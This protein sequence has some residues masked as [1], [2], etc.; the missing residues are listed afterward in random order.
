MIQLAHRQ[1]GKNEGEDMENVLVELA[2]KVDGTGDLLELGEVERLQLVV[3][4]DLE[5]T[6][7]VLEVGHADV[8]E[9]LVA[10]EDQVTGLGQVRG[11]EG[12]ELDTPE[13]ELAG[14]LLERGERSGADVAEGHVLGAGQVG[15]GDLEGLRVTGEVH[16]A[17]G[18]LQVLDVD[19][20]HILV[21]GDVELADLLQG[22]TVEAGQTGV[23]DVDIAGIGDTLVEAQPLQ[24]GQSGEL[25]GADLGEGGQLQGGEAGEAVQVEGLLDA[26]EFGGGDGSDV[27]GHLGR[28]ATVNLL[29]A[30]EAQIARG[31]LFDLEV[32]LDGLAAAVL[33]EIALVLDLDSITATAVYP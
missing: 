24:H 20:L 1:G 4:G 33:L 11:A 14:Q 3:T 23:S 12:L 18:V 16:E 22:D 31:L 9:L 30:I 8:G 19:L 21:V 27:L 17:G 26:V 32:T 25:D 5:A 29:D 10:L 2:A 6:V 13:A 15:Q 28:E 7:D